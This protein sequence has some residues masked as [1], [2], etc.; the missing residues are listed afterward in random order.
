VSHIEHQ[1]DLPAKIIIAVLTVSDSRTESNDKSGRLIIRSLRSRGHYIE[2]YRI[3]KN[4]PNEIKSVIDTWI[5]SNMIQAIIISGGTGISHKDITVETLDPLLEK[6]LQGFGELFRFLSYE[7]IGTS[8]IMSRALAG[9]LD[10]R[11]VI[12]IPGS[13]EAVKLAMEKIIIPEIGHMVREAS[14]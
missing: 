3:V 1:A 2:N 4:D 9:T 13:V 11:V 12:S 5:S 6:K 7:E 14:R 10:G 8:A